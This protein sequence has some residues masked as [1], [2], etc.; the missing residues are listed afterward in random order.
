MRGRFLSKEQYEDVR[1]ILRDIESLDG[2]TAFLFNKIN[3]QMDATVGFININQNK[4][5]K[6]LTIISVIFMPLN[7]LAGVG[8]M[9]EYSMMT[10][11]IPWEISYAGFMMGLMTVGWLTFLGLKFFEHRKLKIPR[12]SR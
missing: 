10:Q 4:D 5:I 11:G 1:E 9:S 3:F 2:H 6:R 7:L 12:K 8:G